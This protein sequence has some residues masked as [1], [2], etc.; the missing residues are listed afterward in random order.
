MAL[1]AAL[2]VARFYVDVRERI[3]PDEGYLWYGALRTLAGEVPVR[4]F[5]SYEPGRYYWSALWLRVLGPGIVPLRIAMHAFLF[6]GLTCGLLSLR[7]AGA[8]WAAV[9]AAGVLLAAWTYWQYKPFEPACGL[10]AVLAG[11]VVLLHP[12]WPAVVACGAVAG[13]ST[14]FGLNIALYSTA[15]LAGLAVLAAAQPGDALGLGTAVLAFGGGWCAGALPLAAMAVAVRGFGARLVQRRVRTVVARGTTN[16]PIPVPWPWR[17]I[18]LTGQPLS[19]FGWRLLGVAFVVLPMFGLAVV[20]WAALADRHDVAAHA[21]LV[22]GATVGAAWLHH[23]FSRADLTHLSTGAT[24]FLVALGALFTGPGWALFPVLLVW[25][26]LTVVAGNPRVER[27]RWRAAF[28][29][30]DTG[31]AGI[32]MLRQ[33]ATLLDAASSA[34]GRLLDPEEPLFA[35]PTLALLFPV[36]GRRSAVYDTY[37]VYPAS[38]GEQ[39]AM[40]ESLERERTRLAFVEDAPLDGRDEL[41]FSR[42]H[43]AVWAY[44]T[45]RFE[46]LEEEGMPPSMHVFWRESRG[47]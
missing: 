40:I 5:R 23:A 28:V 42:T 32:W 3:V 6:G 46:P 45:S 12:G 21:A 4:D 27:R 26:A 9:A 34:A 33:E 1:A 43:P 13:G 19:W 37:C 7:L 25:S 47:L 15:S 31:G 14:F 30:R 39:E 16:L 17:P 41:L 10:A 8:S 35:A 18:P 38:T 22:S 36:L 2:T 44:L 11:V 29:R 20:V 24:P